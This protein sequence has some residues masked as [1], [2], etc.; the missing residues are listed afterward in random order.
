MSEGKRVCPLREEETDA[1]VC[2]EH[3]CPTV[4]CSLFEEQE[5]ALKPG[6]VIAKRFEIVKL[7]GKGAMGAVFLG[8]QLSMSR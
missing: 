1:E 3:G 5:E 2:A 8:K 6:T 4:E 7:L